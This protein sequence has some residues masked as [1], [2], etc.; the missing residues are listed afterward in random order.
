MCTYFI[1]RLDLA[2]VIIFVVDLHDTIIQ[3]YIILVIRRDL[4]KKISAF[5]VHELNAKLDDTTRRMDDRTDP[6][7]NR[8]RTKQPLRLKTSLPIIH[9]TMNFNKSFLDQI[10]IVKLGILHERDKN[11]IPLA[12]GFTFFGR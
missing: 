5:G 4:R 11:R 3:N 9:A 2:G 10:K 8:R 12:D 7:M 1:V 6:L